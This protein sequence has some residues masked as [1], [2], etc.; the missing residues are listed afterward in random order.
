MSIENLDNVRIAVAIK[1]ARTAIG[2]S[3]LELAELIGVSKITLARVE[4]LESTLKAESYMQALRVFKERGVYIDPISTDSI[5]LEITLGCL[6]TV[7]DDSKDES[8][9]RSDKKSPSRQSVE[10]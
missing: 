2:L 7:L 8:K 1:V 6:K 10:K 5:H 9:R 4:T 3:Q